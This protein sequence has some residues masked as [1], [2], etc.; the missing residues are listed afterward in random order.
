M[1]DLSIAI[2]EIQEFVDR[3]VQD[4]RL[5]KDNY[6]KVLFNNRLLKEFL[7]GRNIKELYVRHYWYDVIKSTMYGHIDPFITNTAKRVKMIYSSI[8][9]FFNQRVKDNSLK[10]NENICKTLFE[11][12]ETKSTMKLWM[13]S[14][15]IA[16]RKLNELVQ[17][18]FKDE[19]EME[20][21]RVLGR[22]KVKIETFIK[23]MFNMGELCF[24]SSEEDFERIYRC[25]L[26][27][28]EKDK[29]LKQVYMN[30][31]KVS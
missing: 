31:S 4:G 12:W 29:D 11:E 23:Y 26:I 30:Y 8:E 25:F 22:Q 9:E 5:T 7:S 14:R 24:H 15:I 27:L 21:A 18:H 6:E 28:N 17:I 19:I 10:Y 2:F 16:Q 20:A 1:V 13:D 3:C